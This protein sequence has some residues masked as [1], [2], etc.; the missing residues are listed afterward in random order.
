MTQ[1]S[2]C[3][4]IEFADLNI[5]FESKKPCA[6]RGASPTK[7]FLSICLAA[8]N[9]LSNQTLDRLIKK[10]ESQI[11]HHLKAPSLR[12]LAVNL[13]SV[14]KLDWRSYTN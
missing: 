1:S 14:D 10:E 3:S 9:S 11:L 12:G 7:N 6:P 13:E 4:V 2:S 8:I 5:P